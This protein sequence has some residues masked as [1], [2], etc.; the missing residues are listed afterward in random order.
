MHKEGGG[1]YF[2][3]VSSL[4]YGLDNLPEYNSDTVKV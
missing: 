4:Y 2:S 1:E 3:V